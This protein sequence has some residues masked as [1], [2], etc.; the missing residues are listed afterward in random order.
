VSKF[1]VG[2]LL[3]NKRRKDT[4]LVVIELPNEIHQYDYFVTTVPHGYLQPYPSDD[5]ENRYEVYFNG[6]SLFMGVL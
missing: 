2:D 1:K 3:Y 6:I 5:L 4:H